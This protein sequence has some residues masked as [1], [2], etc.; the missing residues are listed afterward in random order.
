MASTDGISLEDDSEEIPK[1]RQFSDRDIKLIA[2]LAV[3]IPAFR[4]SI[5]SSLTSIMAVI[6]I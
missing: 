3:R 6:D 4:I 5:V 2:G 1:G